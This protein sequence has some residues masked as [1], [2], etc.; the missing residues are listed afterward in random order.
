MQ[1]YL[2]VDSAQTEK[3]THNQDRSEDDNVPSIH[4][5]W[6]TISTFC[7]HMVHMALQ[8]SYSWT[9]RKENHKLVT[10]ACFCLSYPLY[11][12]DDKTH[13]YYT[14]K[15]AIVCTP[16]HAQSR[17]DPPQ[18]PM[19]RLESGA[20]VGGKLCLRAALV[21]EAVYL[22]WCEDALPYDIFNHIDLAPDTLIPTE[23]DDGTPFS[24]IFSQLLMDKKGL[25]V[26]LAAALIMTRWYQMTGAECFTSLFPTE[27]STGQFMQLQGLLADSSIKH[28]AAIKVIRDEFTRLA[29]DIKQHSAGQNRM[30]FIAYT[31][32][33]MLLSGSPLSISHITDNMPP[34]FRQDFD[35]MM[36]IRD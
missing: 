7:R 15:G 35:R 10:D 33:R 16:V 11:N 6:A 32:I 19:I 13:I 27:W 4:P 24:Q 25:G 28:S 34:E 17:S 14:T 31:Y 20:F 1:K 5:E 3:K 36:V 12:G 2:D 21:S 29:E 26:P 18:Q 23:T 22:M 8:D 9:R 30:N